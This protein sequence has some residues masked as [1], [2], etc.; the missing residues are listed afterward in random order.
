MDDVG[1]PLELLDGLQDAAC[2]EGGALGV[3]VI[4]LSVGIEGHLASGKV[5]VVVDEIDLHPGCRDACHLDDERVVG[6]VD[7]NVDTAQPDDFVQLVPPL[8]DDAPFGHEGAYFPAFLL[9]S[10]GQISAHRGHVGLRHKRQH[11]LCDE[12]Y[13]LGFGH[14]C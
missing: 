8:V 1:R 9:N 2:I 7:H 4:F 12:E 5:V 14:L 13:L 11:L 6:V 10:L 3:V